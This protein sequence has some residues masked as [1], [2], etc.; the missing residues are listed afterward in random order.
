MRR[1]RPNAL[2]AERMSESW[3]R[4]TLTE[5]KCLLGTRHVPG[6]MVMLSARQVPCV[7]VVRADERVHS[8]HRATP[9]HGIE[10]VL[11]VKRPA[12][13]YDACVQVMFMAYH[14][15]VLQKERDMHR[16]SRLASPSS[17]G[18]DKSRGTESNVDGVRRAGGREHRFAAMAEAALAQV[19]SSPSL[20]TH[21]AR[22][23]FPNRNAWRQC[24]LLHLPRLSMVALTPNSLSG[25]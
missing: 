18:G 6:G 17:A 14:S 10:L 1:R 2:T 4:E 19:R 9:P 13:S 12:F 11:V 20:S 25:T 15:E 23:W 8:F 16:R 21:R 22:R 3:S 7:I 5:Y 24:L